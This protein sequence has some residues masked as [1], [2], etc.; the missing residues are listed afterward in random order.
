MSVD[1]K[2]YVMIEGGNFRS[3]GAEAMLL[4]MRDAIGRYLPD[5]VPCARITL[6]CS[7]EELQREGIL[8]ITFRD[9]SKLDK[10]KGGGDEKKQVRVSG[11][12]PREDEET[13]GGGEHRSR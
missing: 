10:V 1:K 3:K 12:H 13:R 4:T 11:Q 9:M 8:P 2:L 7:R 5:A 6:P